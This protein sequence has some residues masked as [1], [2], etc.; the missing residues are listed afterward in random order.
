M[1]FYV[2]IDVSKQKLD[3]LWLRDPEALKVKTKVFSNSAE[4]HLRL[5]EWLRKTVSTEESSIHVV[6]E[7]TGVYHE[8]LA[9][10]LE[11][12]GFLVSI[13]NPA[14]IRDF[15]KGLG[16]RHKTDKKD[17]LILARYGA[18][19][20]PD[21]WVPEPEE[22]RALKA[23]LARLSALEKDLQRELNRREKAEISQS[24]A[25]VLDSIT[26]MVDQLRQEVARVR[27]QIDDHIDR[28]PDLKSDRE[29]L[30]SIPA[31][32]QVMSRE[33]LGVLRGRDFNNAG[34]VAA[35]MGLVPKLQESGQWRGRTTLT[36]NGNSR[37]RAKLYLAAVVATKHNPD[38]RAQ[39]QR[40]LKAGKTKMQAIGAAMRKLVQICYGVLKH[41][42]E[43]Q[44]Q[45][46]I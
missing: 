6:M 19:V 21:R 18:L 33:M 43:Y 32:A 7:A 2:G 15:A 26:V 35:F 36:K 12:Q 25:V 1:M 24:S 4:G 14:F 38:V 8:A 17:S 31:I 40:L 16:S 42:S 44:P 41:Q 45:C 3:C 30:S 37:L 5:G 20:Q 29:L 27:Q 46:A 23:L 9:Y 39:Y 22:I 34:Q 10:A 11:A 13:V 28:H